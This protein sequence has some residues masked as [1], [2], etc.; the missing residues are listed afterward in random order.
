MITTTAKKYTIGL[1]SLYVLFS[2]CRSLASAPGLLLHIIGGTNVNSD[3][4]GSTVWH[5]SSTIQPGIAGRS[6]D[7][8][9]LK[10]KDQKYALV[11]S[12][13]IASNL[14]LRAFPL[15]MG[16]ERKKTAIGR[17]DLGTRMQRGI[18]KRLKKAPNR[19]ANN[20][21]WVDTA[22]SLRLKRNIFSFGSSLTNMKAPEWCFISIC[23]H[24]FPCLFYIQDIS[25]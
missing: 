16:R 21:S 9:P 6:C 22:F 18:K 25:C 2:Q 14:S 8:I 15:E 10:H 19:H 11:R 1:A 7:Y 12:L 5:K 23:Y 4:P 13:N 24:S 20:D 17:K 3:I